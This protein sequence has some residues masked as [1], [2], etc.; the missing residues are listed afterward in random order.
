MG[1]FLG[2]SNTGLVVGV[3]LVVAVPLIIGRIS[4]IV[5]W[6]YQQKMEMA[7]RGTLGESDISARLERL[8]QAVG[9]IAR[10]MQRLSESQHAV[11]ELPPARVAA[12]TEVSR[13]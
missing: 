12:D 9:I 4:E 3:M 11:A 6:A 10:E 1:S 7:K 13:H 2:M 5:R 8:E